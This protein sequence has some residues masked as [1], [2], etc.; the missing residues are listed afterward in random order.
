[1]KKT[2][3]VSITS[4]DRVVWQGS[5]DSVSSTNKKGDFDILPQH[6]N[7]ITIIQNKPI[8]IRIGKQTLKF[9][10]EQSVMYTYNNYVSFYVF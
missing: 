6:A 10:F 4:P 3:T 8:V 9:T 7:F 2:L 1:M 5:A